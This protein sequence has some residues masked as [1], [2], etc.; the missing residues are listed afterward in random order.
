MFPSCAR[1]GPFLRG[2]LRAP[3][4]PILN[5]KITSIGFPRTFSACVPFRRHEAR[6]GAPALAPLGRPHRGH[7]PLVTFETAATPGTRRECFPALQSRTLVFLPCGAGERRKQ[8]PSEGGNVLGGYRRRQGQPGG[9]A[10]GASECRYRQKD[11]DPTRSYFNRTISR[12]R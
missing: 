12:V 5:S 1:V 6:T 3:I 2:G 9:G 10:R 8:A 11:I 7:R 4:Y